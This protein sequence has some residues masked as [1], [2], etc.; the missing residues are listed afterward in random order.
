MSMTAIRLIALAA[1]ALLPFGVV[2]EISGVTATNNL[3]WRPAPDG[4]PKGA[5][6]ALL[7]GDPGKVGEFVIRIRMP[8]GYSVPPHKHASLERLTIISGGL[9]YG[10]GQQIDPAAEKY[11]HAGDFIVAPAEMGH[12]VTTNDETVLQ[13]DSVGPF[14]ITYF[15]P[16]DDPR[17]AQR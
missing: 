2:A 17:M 6:F 7:Y 4:L 8:K 10:M 1:I 13:L 9:R 12:W 14:S 11:A 16:K 15:N 3:Q 5:E